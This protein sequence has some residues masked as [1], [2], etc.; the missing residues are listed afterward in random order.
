MIKNS[1][2]GKFIVFD[3]LDGSGLSTQSA[4]LTAYLNKNAK[5]NF[6]KAGAWLTKEP[7]KNLIGGLINAQLG[8][9]WKSSPECLQLLF[10]A[11]R[12]FHLEKE[13]I[14]LLEKGITVICD[15]YLFS[16]LA[17]GTFAI[18]DME[19][20]VGLQSRFLMPDATFFLKVAPKLCIERINSNRFEEALF[21]KQEILGKVWRNYEQLAKRLPD[22]Y[23]IDG[24]GSIDGIHKKIVSIINSKK[25]I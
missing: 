21:E 23:I 15:R 14:P 1:Y 22:I 25:I 16:S 8:H 19:W 18:N 3:G 24:E 5:D 7:T 10:A 6:G 9:H 11:D 13:I 12:A 4:L 20:L 2:P 17:F